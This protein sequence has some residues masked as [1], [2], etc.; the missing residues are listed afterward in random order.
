MLFLDQLAF[1]FVPNVVG[2]VVSV[3]MM[4]HSMNWGSQRYAFPRII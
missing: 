3:H 4:G 2:S 1:E